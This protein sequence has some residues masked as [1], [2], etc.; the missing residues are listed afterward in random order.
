MN[1]EIKC[2]YPRRV[3]P[4]MIQYLPQVCYTGE[5]ALV[6]TDKI[7]DQALVEISKE[8]VLGFDTETRPNFT[9]GKNYPVSILQ[10]G[11]EKKVWIIRLDPLKDRLA[12]I[13]KIL[14]NPAVKKA[15]IAVKGDIKSLRSRHIFNPAGFVD[16]SD[17]TSNLGVVN[18]GMRN[19]TALIFGEKISK[20]A[21]LTNWASEN[22][23]P[24][25]IQYAATDAW[26]SR[27]LFLEIKKVVEQNRT[28]IE[29]EPEPE[30]ESKKF[31]LRSFVKL[32]IKKI[33]DALGG[34]NHGAA[35]S[36][37]KRRSKKTGLRAQSRAE[38]RRSPGAKDAGKKSRSGSSRPSG[39]NLPTSVKI[40]VQNRRRAKPD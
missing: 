21:Q 13:Y 16:V 28:I 31:N 35:S 2:M 8:K 37:P 7:L 6:E 24:K 17:Y 20:S 36:S 5:I 29:P 3:N 18:T 14:E 4:D 27:R 19:L 30:Q 15:G 22:L 40:T 23:T 34:K 39:K 26:I 9:K 25:Q 11:G 10:L 12:D 33:F 38:C 1:F 32:T